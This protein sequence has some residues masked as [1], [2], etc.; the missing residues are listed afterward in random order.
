LDEGNVGSCPEGFMRKQAGAKSAR[1]PSNRSNPRAP[2]PHGPTPRA[3]P[4]SPAPRR[5]GAWGWR[6]GGPWA[7]RDS[8]DQRCLIPMLKKSHM[9]I[10]FVRKP[11]ITRSLGGSKGLGG[12]V[13]F[14]QTKKRGERE[15]GRS[16]PV[17]L[18][19]IIFKAGL[20][21]KHMYTQVTRD[22]AEYGSSDVC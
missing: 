6:G 3:S 7:S 14:Q 11:W 10:T 12:N 17:L 19:A 8:N 18:C 15:M 13:S 4:G 20:M 2:V 16:D 1:E 21:R 9:R 22:G 5:G